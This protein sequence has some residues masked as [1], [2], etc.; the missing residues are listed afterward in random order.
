VDYAFGTGFRRVV[1][2]ADIFNIGNLQRTTGYNYYYEYPDF[3]TLNP[4]F[5]TPGN[6]V[7]LNAF[8]TPMQV[9]FGAKFEF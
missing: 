7:T 4:D 6:P 8:Q 1:L 2:I 9:R 3:G 5:G